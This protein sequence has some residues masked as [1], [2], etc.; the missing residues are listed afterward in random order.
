MEYSIHGQGIT[1]SERTREYVEK[2]TRKLDR[3]MPDLRDVRVDLSETNAR[4]VTKKYA[5]QI[6]I[7]DARGTIL[8][9]EERSED[10]SISIDAVVDKLYRQIRKYR[11]KQQ[12]NSRAGGEKFIVGDPL[13]IEEAVNLEYE[14]HTQDIV[15]RKRFPLSPMSTEE[16][17]DQMELL[18]HDFFVF[19][20]ADEEQ[21][22]VIYRR[23]DDNYGLLQ[24]EM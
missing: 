10:I 9:A 4:N 6:T 17:I 7:R 19:F 20:N 24:P 5:A 22:N 1:I 18:G 3:Y 2:R 13:P 12:R 8:R 11:G 15:R 23:H 14:G 16:A 21:T